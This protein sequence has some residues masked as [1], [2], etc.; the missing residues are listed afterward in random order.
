MLNGEKSE[1]PEFPVRSFLTTG[2]KS[3]G[4]TRGD[5]AG[6]TETLR[7]VQDRLDIENE[8]IWGENKQGFKFAPC[9]FGG[10]HNLRRD[11]HKAHPLQ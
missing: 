7:G 11:S 5:T 4:D 8:N 10:S 9:F 1:C 6:W 2:D 3:A